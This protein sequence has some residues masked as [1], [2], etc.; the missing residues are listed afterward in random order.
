[1]KTMRFTAR[2]VLSLFICVICLT[3]NVFA[4]VSAKWFAIYNGPADIREYPNK[5]VVDG[6][7]NVYVTGGV[8]VTGVGPEYPTDYATIKYDKDGNQLWVAYYDGTAS[9]YD[10]PSD[11]FVDTNGNVYVTGKSTGTGGG[12]GYDVATV[13][14]D[15]SGNQLWAV[16]YNGPDDD[17]DSG[18]GIAVDNNGNAYVA[19]RSCIHGSVGFFTMIKYDPDGNELWVNKS[20]EG[21]ARGVV[22]DD[23]GKIYATGIVTTESTKD[24][25]RTIKYDSDGNVL[26]MR[27]FDGPASLWDVPFELM[28]DSSGNV[29]L[30]GYSYGDGTGRDYVALKYDNNGNEL[31]VA[32]YDNVGNGNDVFRAFTLDS[33]GN[34]Y[35]MGYSDDPVSGNRYGT[36]VKYDTTGNQQWVKSVSTTEVLSEYWTPRSCATDDS[37]NVYV[38]GD[39]YTEKF[40]IVKYDADGHQLWERTFRGNTEYNAVATDNQGNVYV[41]GEYGDNFLTIKLNPDSLVGPIVDFSSNMVGG[42]APLTV[43]FTDLTIGSVDSWYWDFDGDLVADSSSQ[44]PSHTFTEPGPHTVTLH[45]KGTDGTGFLIKEKY[46][47]VGGLTLFRIRNRNCL[48]GDRIRIIGSGFGDNQGSSVIHIGNKTFDST[49]RRIKLWTDTKI[50][51]KIPNYKCTWF[52]GKTYRKRKVRVTVD[53]VDTAIKTIR[54]SRPITCF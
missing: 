1:M 52:K 33:F 11:L 43:E 15:S 29:Y 35:L 48:P 13:K 32:R 5:V 14:Y 50:K 34:S 26:W 18:Y 31:W 27:D 25:F 24:D 51:I 19:G 8:A 36:I 16:R 45:V 4:D 37:G 6:L 46:I 39:K 7:G 41:T 9:D 40:K 47:T 38:V 44:N 21:Q 22:V 10:W 12:D 30:G 42:E 49:S 54:V 2:I 23:S 20:D 53:G 3:Q 17:N 28:L